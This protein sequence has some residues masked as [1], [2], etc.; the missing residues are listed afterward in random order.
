MLVVAAKRKWVVH[1]LD[2]NNAFLRNDLIEDVYMQI[3][4]GFTKKGDT[5]VR[6]LKKSLYDLKQASHNWYHKFTRA[7]LN[8]GFRQSRADHS[9][10][11][12]HYGSIYVFALIYVDDVLLAGK[13]EAKIQ[14]IKSYFDETFSIKDLGPL[15]YFLGIEVAWSYEGFVL[16]QHKYT[17]DILEESGLQGVKPSH[18]SVEH[19]LKLGINDDGVHDDSGQ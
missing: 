13:N 19:N 15:K 16:S 9:L 18:F 1:Q 6:K 11:A 7:L 14:F 3:P 10:F 2:V 4:Q 12:F 8:I 17:L 5:Q